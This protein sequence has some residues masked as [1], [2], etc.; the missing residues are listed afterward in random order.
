M[1][2]DRSGGYEVLAARLHRTLTVYGVPIGA[3]VD[4][5]PPPERL[6]RLLTLLGAMALR[7]R[8]GL[9]SEV[10]LPAEARGSILATCYWDISR[11]ARDDD[12]AETEFAIEVVNERIGEALAVLNVLDGGEGEAGVYNVVATLLSA[13]GLLLTSVTAD[14]DGEMVMD[15]DE[16]VVVTPKSLFLDARQRV[17]SVADLL[18]SL[19]VD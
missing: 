16:P 7:L 11:H 14:E 1:G 19:I 6:F 8:L 9:R 5:A 3:D 2:P 15:G 12:E 10:P 18:D 13:A 4:A 17:R